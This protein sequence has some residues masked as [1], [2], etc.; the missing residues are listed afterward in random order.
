MILIKLSV[1]LNRI[2]HTIESLAKTVDAPEFVDKQRHILETKI[3]FI[4]T[5]YEKIF[6]KDAFVA[7]PLDCGNN[8]NL[9][10]YFIIYAF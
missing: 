6:G 10:K 8:S 3:N 4:K 5:K 7:K 1:T 9:G 2:Q